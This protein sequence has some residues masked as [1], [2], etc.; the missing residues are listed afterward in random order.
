MA[1]YDPPLF[2]QL[3]KEFFLSV[4]AQGGDAPLARNACFFCEFAHSECSGVSLS[5]ACMCQ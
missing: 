4:L 5:V 2:M 3:N 1:V